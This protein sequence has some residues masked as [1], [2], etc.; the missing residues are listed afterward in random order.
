LQGADEQEEEA[1]EDQQEVD[2]LAAQVFLVEE[3]GA[4]EEAYYDAAAADHGDYG[5]HGGA[6][7]QGD[8]VGVVSEGQED[9]YE[10]D[11]PLPLEGGGVLAGGPPHGEED[12]SHQGQLVEVTPCLYEH[13]VEAS[14]QVFVKEGADGS[15]QGGH[16]YAEHPFVLYEIDALLLAAQTEQIEGD[17]GNDHTYPL[18]EV[19]ALTEQQQAAQQNDDGTGGVDGAEQ[20]DGQVFHAEVAE[21]PGAKHDERLEHEQAVQL[22]A[23]CGDIKNTAVQQSCLG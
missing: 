22:P 17:D 3:E 7:G 19:Q 10:D 11:G 16:D 4:A 23:G 6:L 9:C 15:Q 13:V 2:D 12:H 1:E 5:Y 14:Q 18:V 21:Y 8:E 20:G